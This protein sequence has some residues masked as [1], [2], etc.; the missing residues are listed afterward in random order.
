[1]L[2]WFWLLFSA[3]AAVACVWSHVFTC[4]KLATGVFL[5][6]CSDQCVSGF[7]VVPIVLLLLC[8]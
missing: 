5:S 7:V 6:C 1:M 3:V 2:W 8:M 4:L